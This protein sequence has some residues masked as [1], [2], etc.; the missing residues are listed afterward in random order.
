MTLLRWDPYR[1]FVTLSERSHGTWVP[2][3]DIFEKDDVLFL[4]AELPG[5]SR[6]EIDLR[7]ENG[8]LTLSGERRRDAALSEGTRRRL[9]RVH[10]TFT[11]RFTLPPSVDAGKIEASHRDGVL[12]I[13]LPKSEASKPKRV[14][15]HAA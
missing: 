14:E 7:V 10:G 15:I 8:V 5:L 13:R 3:V 9:E 11:R 12:E 4:R 2:P 1:E 6:E